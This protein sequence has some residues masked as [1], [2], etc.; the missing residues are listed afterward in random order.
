MS[1]DRE[2]LAAALAGRWLSYADEDGADDLAE[3]PDR[4]GARITATHAGLLADALLPVV[5]RIATARAAAELRAAAN[6]LHLNI[7]G[8]QGLRDRADELDRGKS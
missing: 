6:D 4:D 3:H 8:K 1:G 7:S 5:D 2:L